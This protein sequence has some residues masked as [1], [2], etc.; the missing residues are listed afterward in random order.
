MTHQWPTGSYDVLKKELVVVFCGL[1]PSIEA[2]TTGHNFGSASNRFWRAL[3]LAGFTSHQIAAEDDRILLRFG[4]GVT[5]AIGRPT[6]SAGEIG[7]IEFRRSAEAFERK[8]AYYRPHV[9]A[10]LGK[11][12]YAAMTGLRD[13]DWGAQSRTFGSSRVWLL[14][15][16]S[17]LNRAFTLDRLVEHYGFLRADV[18]QRLSHFAGGA[19]E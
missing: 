10:F 16:P 19:G 2:A 17:G 9:I 18:A 8:V 11:S 14:P 12:A 7:S 4:C 5:A 13:L 1:N 15:N 3:H 6:R